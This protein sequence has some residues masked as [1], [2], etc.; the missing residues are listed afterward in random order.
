[1][2]HSEEQLYY[3]CTNF[4]EAFF[5][6]LCEKDKTR[7]KW[8][9]DDERDVRLR[10]AN[11]LLD[12]AYERLFKAVEDWENDCKGVIGQNKYRLKLE[13]VDLE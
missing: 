6:L 9:P 12:N 10:F 4:C 8:C 13:R 11:E 7:S 2:S 1:M 5:K 3:A